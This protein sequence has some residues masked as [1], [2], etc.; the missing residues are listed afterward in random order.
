VFR[1]S[2][3]AWRG[4]CLRWQESRPGVPPPN[5]T[6]TS[7]TWL[8]ALLR[9]MEP[10]SSQE[11]S[12]DPVCMVPGELRPSLGS[13]WDT[14]TNQAAMPCHG[15]SARGFGDGAG[16]VATSA[17]GGA[18]EKTQPPTL[19]KLMRCIKAVLRRCFY[20]IQGLYGSTNRIT[21]SVLCF[22]QY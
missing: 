21:E 6:E 16:C 13:D 1:S 19:C 5:C 15:A 11:L 22:Q 9:G 20:V 18:Q 7:S 4:L 8:P 12:L 2:V 10:A 17:G 14:N 3:G